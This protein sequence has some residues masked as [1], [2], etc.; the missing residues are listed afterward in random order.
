MASFDGLKQL[1]Q[2]IQIG[3]PK[4]QK[5]KLTFI[6]YPIAALPGQG[7]SYVPMYNPTSFSVS[8]EIKHDELGALTVGNMVKKFLSANP[9]TVSMELFF[10]GTGASPSSLG[11]S[12]ND[13][14]G[15][16]SVENQINNFLLGAYQISGVI[17]RPNFIMIIWGSFIMTG[18]L[19]SANVTY[20]MF[21][22]DGSPLRAKLA[23]TIKEHTESK[24][25]IKA[26][27]LQSPDLSKSI[28]VQEGD[29]L[30]LL[31]FREYGDASYYIKV[32]KVNN[33]KNY[34]KL[35]Q[36][37]ELLFPPINNLT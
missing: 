5:G 7:I 8:H 26:L 3:K 24:L 17:H 19:S 14:S 29:T 32:A 31:C 18:V 6:F 25:L 27:S 12:A 35:I 11:V 20:T 30:P 1:K 23:I 21:A 16:Q 33:L 34:R 10:D 28:T 15:I 2:S 22:T 9:R 37:T 36:G 13:L 4:G